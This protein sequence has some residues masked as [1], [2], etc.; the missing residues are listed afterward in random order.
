MLTLGIDTAGEQGAVGL[1]RGAEGLSELNFIATLQHGEKLLPAIEAVLRWGEVYQEELELI[2]V[3]TG[4]GSFTGLRI[5]MAVAK[6]LARALE[7]PLVGV[8]TLAAY[9]RMVSFWPGPV[10][11]LMPD[12]R[13]LVYWAGYRNGERFTAERVEPIETL[14]ASLLREPQGSLLIGPGAERHRS[15]IA[16]RAPALT[17]APA[18]FNRPSGLQVAWLGLATYQAKGQD[19]RDTLEPLYAQAP[20]AQAKGPNSEME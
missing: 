1:C 16:Q 3:S 5:G 18:I 14:L 6:G 15:L 10:Y 20:L 17:I 7:V 13:E 19:E 11:A 2:A 4:P 12:R 9:A 8:P